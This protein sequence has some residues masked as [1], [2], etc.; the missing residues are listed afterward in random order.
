[1]SRAQVNRAA[2]CYHAVVALLML[3]AGGALLGLGIHLT[4][5]DHAGPIDLEYGSNSFLDFVLRAG[6]LCIV[7]GSFIL[8]TAVCALVAL[9]R[10]CVGQTFRVI[11]IML[12][13]L[14]LIGLIFIT[15]VS[16]LVYARRATP[17]VR[18]FFSDA[19]E[20]TVRERP[21]AIC[22]IESNLECRGFADVSCQKEECA[23]CP[24]ETTATSRLPTQIGESKPSMKNISCYQT[25]KRDLRAVYLPAAIVGTILSVAVLIDVFVVCAL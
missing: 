24:K 1:M 10:R 25:I 15:V 21:S 14:V 16:W 17:L 20:R 7:I 12:A 19:W 13:L 22:K 2:S 4:V 5:S 9:G 18:D 11:Y 6:I 23:V 3:L 8:I